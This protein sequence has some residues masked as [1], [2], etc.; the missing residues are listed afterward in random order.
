MKVNL[1]FPNLDLPAGEEVDMDAAEAL[2]WCQRGLAEAADAADLAAAY[3]QQRA[4]V[5]G[6]APPA[7]ESPVPDV[8]RSGIPVL[9]AV[10][11]DQ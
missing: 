5:E 8:D 10:N 11:P 1:L 4:A 9:P 7:P 6:M 3:E 2:L